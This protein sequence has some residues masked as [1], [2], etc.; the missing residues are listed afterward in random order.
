MK[1][2]KYTNQLENGMVHT[3]LVDTE[4]KKTL[5]KLTD[6]EKG[7][8]GHYFEPEALSQENLNILLSGQS[9][10]NLAN[11][12]DSDTKAFIHHFPQI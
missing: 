3:F 11:T 9:N 6:K 4:T 1:L 5:V 7:L 12:D 2:V 8:V 10:W